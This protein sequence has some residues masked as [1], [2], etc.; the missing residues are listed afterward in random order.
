MSD[1][2]NE[3]EQDHTRQISVDLQTFMERNLEDFI[4]P[5]SMTLFELMESS[6]S[7]QNI[8]PDLWEQAAVTVDAMNVANDHAE[9][10]VASIQELSGLKNHDETQLQFLLQTV[11]QHSTGKCIPTV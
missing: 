2:R 9:R 10:G 5:K 1:I 6:H 3:T 11:H 8:D 4:T 7:F